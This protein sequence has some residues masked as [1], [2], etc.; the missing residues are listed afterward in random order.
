[1]AG[2]LS[3]LKIRVIAAG[4]CVIAALAA[5]AVAAPKPGGTVVMAQ[6]GNIPTLDPHFSGS[7]ETR[8]VVTHIYEGL[9]ALDENANAIPDLADSYSFAADGRSVT[10]KLRHAV[11]FHNGAEMKAA[12]VV[13]S[14]GRYK[15]LSPNK[16][17][18]AP[19][20]AAEALDDYTV[21]LRLSRK[22]PSLV[23]EMASP[24]TVPGIMPATDGTTAGGKNSNIGTGPYKYSAFVA[25]SHATLERFADYTPNPNYQKRDGYGGRKT[26]YFDRVIIRVV[27]EAG[28]RVAGLETGEY[29]IVE[30][31]PPAVAN[32]LAKNKSLRIYDMM[33]WWMII[34]WLNNSLAPTDNI[35]VR[36]AIQAVVNQKEVMAFATQDFYRLNYSFQYPTS[37]WY[38]GPEAQPLYNQGNAAKA[39]ELLAKAGQKAPKLTVVASADFDVCANAGIVVAEQLKTAG[40]QVDLRTVDHPTFTAMRQKPEG[41]NIEICGAGIEPFL[42]A[43]AYNRLMAGKPN[44]MQAYGP[45]L[46]AAWAQILNSDTFP[47]RKAGWVKLEAMLHDQALVVKLG[48]AGIKQAAVA[49]V[50]GFVPFRSPRLWDVWFE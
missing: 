35:D 42:G 28:A 22:A 34:A 38:P 24:A 41:W 1:M 46:D 37:S 39:R 23:E 7:G 40:F 48:D 27:P 25:D 32:D 5:P 44:S 36:R 33:P 4:F 50:T 30:Q 6:A 49:K 15:R 3:N 12:D 31:I 20:D 11:K 26:A 21:V 9:V 29:Q 47:Q 16:A 8:N 13:A 19:M 43:Y 14:L 45:E 2:A 18:L 10:F 17:L